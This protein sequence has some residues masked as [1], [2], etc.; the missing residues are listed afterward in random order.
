MIDATNCFITYAPDFKVADLSGKASSEI[1][2]GYVPGSRLVKAFNTL[3]YKLLAKNPQ[4]ESGNRVLFIS[5]DDVDA[6]VEISHIIESMG[7][8]A[9]DLGSIAEGSKLQQT[10]GLLASLNLVKV[11][12]SKAK[13]SKTNT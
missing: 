8:A 12:K 4:E 3:H 7:F 1:V 6:K 13:K 9:V 2:Y 10:K 5:G 11:A